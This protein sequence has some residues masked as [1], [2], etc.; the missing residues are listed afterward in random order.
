MKEYPETH[1]TGYLSVEQI[2]PTNLKEC[3]FGIQIAKDG[4]V[5]V[6]VNGMAFLRFKPSQRIGGKKC[7]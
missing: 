5:W 1:Q 7:L 6:C 3:D 2:I 4:R